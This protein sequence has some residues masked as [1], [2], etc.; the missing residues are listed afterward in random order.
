M[1]RL[2]SDF[3]VTLVDDSVREFH[4][5]FHGPKE[6][7]CIFLL[8]DV[9]PLLSLPWL[10]QHPDTIRFGLPDYSGL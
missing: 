6:S 10:A 8:F 5:M 4:V 7:A 9:S 1:N 2:M 3:E